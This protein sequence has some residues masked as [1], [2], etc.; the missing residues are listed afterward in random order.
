M[1]V[2]K[3]SAR[4]PI[5]K[6]RVRHKLLVV[7]D[8]FDEFLK[9]HKSSSNNPILPMVAQNILHG[10]DFQ[11][12]SPS[13]DRLTLRVHDLGK[14]TQHWS[15]TY[16]EFMA[17]PEDSE[18]YYSPLNKECFHRSDLAMKAFMFRWMAIAPWVESGIVDKYS[19]SSDIIYHVINF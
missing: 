19:F 15:V 16:Y 3:V 18:S 8:A 4:S 6:I 11:M 9:Q 13:M 2:I 10:V 14:T 12:P 1:A 17:S 5:K 7:T